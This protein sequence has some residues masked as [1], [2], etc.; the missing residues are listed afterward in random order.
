LK[1][2]E[3]ISTTCAQNLRCSKHIYLLIIHK[4]QA[5]S[6]F[7]LFLP[8]AIEGKEK[9]YQNGDGL[10]P[11][12]NAQVVDEK[13]KIGCRP[14]PPAPE[15]VLGGTEP[16]PKGGQCRKYPRYNHFGFPAFSLYPLAKA[17]RACLAA[18]AFVP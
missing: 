8:P 13:I 11:F 14:N 1:P 9:I 18:P 3:L 16:G 4:S 7:D 12:V 6:L 15:H 5:R 10:G 17:A 2:S